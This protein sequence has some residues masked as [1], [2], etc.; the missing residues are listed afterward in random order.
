MNPL[1]N[2]TFKTI[3]ENK[4]KPYLKQRMGTHENYY[5]KKALKLTVIQEEIQS[6]K[7]K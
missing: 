2:Q 7:I 6:N 4:M 1:R 5:S 3:M